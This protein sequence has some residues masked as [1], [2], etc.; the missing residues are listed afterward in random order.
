MAGNDHRRTILRQR[1]ASMLVGNCLVAGFQFL[2][3]G[4]ALRGLGTVA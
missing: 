3:Q 2:A 1:R 4:A